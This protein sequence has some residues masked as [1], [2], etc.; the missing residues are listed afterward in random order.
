MVLEYHGTNW[1]EYHGM[2]YHG[3]MVHVYQL[4]SIAIPWYQSGTGVQI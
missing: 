1:Y 4:A 2:P 3:T